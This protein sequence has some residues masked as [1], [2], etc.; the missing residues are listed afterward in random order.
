MR[1][2]LIVPCFLIAVGSGCSAD[3]TDPNTMYMGTGGTVG[4]A[5]TVGVA[6]TATGGGGTGGTPAV[7]GGAGTVGVA[8]STAGG[9]TGGTFVVNIGGGGSTGGGGAGGVA[10]GGGGAGGVAAGGGGAGGQAAGGGGA[11]GGG[12]P[13]SACT[14]ANW[15]IT[16]TDEC[17][18]ANPSC[19]GIPA[20][21]KALDNAIDGMPATRYT[22]GKTQAGDE[23]V[24]VSFGGSVSI[25][26]ITL[27][28]A[29]GDGPVEYTLEYS[30]NGTAFM[31]FAPAVT[32]AGSDNLAITFPATV[33]SAIKIKQTGMVEA[34]ATSWWSI[35]EITAQ[36]CTVQ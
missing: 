28:S 19:P 11:G 23:E 7:T 34:P 4:A 8:G 9:G 15:T 21:A 14:Q 33:M 26:G 18:D 35:F 32:G 5:G 13:A 1:H 29:D 25:T 3:T 31:A 2:S 17:L 10:A 30:T 27:T 16:A 12:N 22:S 20:T 36:G 24:V 6:S